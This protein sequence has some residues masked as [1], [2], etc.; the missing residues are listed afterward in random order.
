[1]AFERLLSVG[2]RVKINGGPRDGRLASIFAYKLGGEH[3]IEYRLLFD[4]EK[5]ETST[6]YRRLSLMTVGLFAYAKVPVRVADSSEVIPGRKG[7]LLGAV[8]GGLCV[9]EAEVDSPLDPRI[10][11]VPARQLSMLFGKTPVTEPGED[12]PTR[13]DVDPD[14]EPPG[15]EPA[16]EVEFLER[17][18]I[19]DPLYGFT[20][21][22]TVY[23]ADKHSI[24]YGKTLTIKGPGVNPGYVAVDWGHGMVGEAVP[25][26]L[27][28]ENPEGSHDPAEP[29]NPFEVIRI[30]P[31]ALGMDHCMSV[32]EAAV[33]WQSRSDG[34]TLSIANQQDGGVV[35]VVRDPEVEKDKLTSI[36]FRHACGHESTIEAIERALAMNAGGATVVVPIVLDA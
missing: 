10:Y 29:T 30:P 16:P 4:G 18:V 34:R 19:A 9:V 3:G 12:P 1:M 15:G 24:L 27:S 11:Y 6:L 36:E 31:L 8:D 2:T 20:V 28:R 32:I 35:L 14:P 17:R 22:E 25:A 13:S 26:L 7:L 5:I 33:D 23:C 21:G